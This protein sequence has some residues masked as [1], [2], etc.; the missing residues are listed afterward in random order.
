MY[1]IEIK[2]VMPDHRLIAGAI[3]TTVG[4][5]SCIMFFLAEC[6]A[7]SLLFLLSVPFFIKMLYMLDEY[8][9]SI[10]SNEKKTGLNYK[11][12]SYI[13]FF[14]T[15][16]GAVVLVAAAALSVVYTAPENSPNLMKELLLKL[17]PVIIVSVII[18]LINI[19]M[20]SNC[21]SRVLNDAAK[22]ATEMP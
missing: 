21:F 15:I 18:V 11:A 19:A 2:H 8:T 9:G 7:I 17:I 1:P 20:L 3:F 10:P 5:S 12:R 13:T 16:F 14:F 22:F 6:N 4:C